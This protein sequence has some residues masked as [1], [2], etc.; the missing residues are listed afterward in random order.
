MMNKG[1]RTLTGSPEPMMNLRRYLRC[2]KVARFFAALELVVALEH[3]GGNKA[4]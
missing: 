3:E 1:A 4:N 2:R